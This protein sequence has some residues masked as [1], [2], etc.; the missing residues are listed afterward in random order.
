MTDDVRPTTWV[1]DIEKKPI[2]WAVPDYIPRRYVTLLVAPRNAGKTM[3]AVWLATEAVRVNGLRVWMNSLEDDLPAVLK[4]RFDAA[5]ATIGRQIRLTDNHWRLPANLDK[6]QAELE[7][8]KAGDA[9]DDML[10]LDSIQQHITRPYTH[11]PVQESISGLMKLAREFDLAVVL[12]G[13]TTKGKHAS[14]E[15]MIG[16]SQVL[17]NLGKAI[18]VFGPEPVSATRAPSGRGVAKNLDEE[19]AELL[20]AEEG[21]P[22]YVMACE[23]MGIALP[24]TSILFERLTTHDEVT[25][26]GEPYLRYIGPSG[27]SA[28][29]VIDAAKTDDRDA[30]EAGKAAQ[31]AMWIAQTLGAQGSMLTKEFEAAAKADGSYHSRN[32]FDR[33]RKIAGVQTGKRGK[34]HYVWLR[35]Q[36]PP[37]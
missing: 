19:L 30:D 12:V 22:R 17:Q 29:D 8:H 18:F 36:E 33:A 25:G 27:A 24:P 16:G 15:A 4:P 32:T 34:A 14:V 5:G 23:R 37:A 11:T 3:C 28:R 9:P 26:R 10:I 7:L 6:L 31:A 20:D 13:H 1:E 35:G 2:K 21:N